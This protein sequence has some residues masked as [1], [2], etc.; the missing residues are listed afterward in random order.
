MLSSEGLVD[1]QLLAVAS[2][3][4]SKRRPLV[5]LFHHGVVGRC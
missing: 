5:S 3:S 1:R 2:K 4:V